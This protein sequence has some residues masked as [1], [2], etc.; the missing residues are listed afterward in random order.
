MLSTTLFMI[1]LKDPVNSNEILG[2]LPY[3][4]KHILEGNKYIPIPAKIA[5]S[6]IDS[7][8]QGHIVSVSDKLKENKN[9]SVSLGDFKVVKPTEFDQ[10]K[11]Q[12]ISKSYE[13]FGATISKTSILKHYMYFATAILLAE[14][15]FLITDENREE[16]YLEIINT[17]DESLLKTLEDYLEARDNLADLTFAY[18]EFQGYVRKVQA[19]ETIDELKELQ[20]DCPF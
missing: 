6:V 12:E 1:E 7:I 17:G 19:T 3:D 20:K 15:G 10:L 16:K 5:E 13:R 8:R 14:N 11:A 4:S 18:K 9:G 2:I